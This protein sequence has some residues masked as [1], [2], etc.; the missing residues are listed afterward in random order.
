MPSQGSTLDATT[1]AAQPIITRG[2]RSHPGIPLGIAHIYVGAQG[3]LP[4]ER[5]VGMS[6]LCGS[7]SS[8][9]AA[10]H[11]D[12]RQSRV[13][14]TIFGPP[15][16]LTGEVGGDCGSR[17]RDPRRTHRGVPPRIAKSR[18]RTNASTRATARPQ[19]MTSATTR[20]T[21]LGRRR[22]LWPTI[23]KGP[24]RGPVDNSDVTRRP[25]R[26]RASPFPAHPT[27]HDL[28][29]HSAA[30]RAAAQSDAVVEVPT[31]PL[32]MPMGRCPEPRNA[33][34]HRSTPRIEDR[35]R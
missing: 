22:S 8:C 23:E 14:P 35:T 31:F 17:R 9:H 26:S 7:G 5:P 28:G 29:A 25:A 12:A 2:S 10:P 16:G 6:A 18:S 30:L 15:P 27:L 33:T 4:A 13:E 34:R 19:R 32:P 24:T 1:I 20:I 11:V 3:R 21:G